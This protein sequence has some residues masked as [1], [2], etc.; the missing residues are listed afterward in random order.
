VPI[1]WTL[2]GKISFLSFAT[3]RI[4]IDGSFWRITGYFPKIDI[5]NHM[6]GTGAGQIHRNKKRLES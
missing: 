3:C 5:Q 2:P 1:R 6:G 4:P